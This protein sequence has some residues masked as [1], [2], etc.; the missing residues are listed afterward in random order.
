LIDLLCLKHILPPT[1]LSMTGKS[2]FKPPDIKLV[3]E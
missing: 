2:T 1:R 3:G